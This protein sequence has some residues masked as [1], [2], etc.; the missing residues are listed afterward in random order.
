ML[1]IETKI[2]I[3][4]GFEKNF[5]WKYHHKLQRLSYF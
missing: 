2:N 3:L 1:F 4:D 5:L